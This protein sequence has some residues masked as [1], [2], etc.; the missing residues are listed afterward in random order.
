MMEPWDAVFSWRG[1]TLAAGVMFLMAAVSYARGMPVDVYAHDLSI[2]FGFT[3]GAFF[4]AASDY[5][6]KAK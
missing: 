6:R 3:L 5:V 1:P 2:A 4:Y